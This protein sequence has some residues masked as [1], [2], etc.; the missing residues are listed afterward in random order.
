MHGRESMSTFLDHFE[1]YF[2]LKFEGNGLDQC[3]ELGR[4]LDGEAK[5]AYDAVGG[6]HIKYKYMKDGLLD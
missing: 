3:T 1:R 5:R 4:F 6:R 2:M